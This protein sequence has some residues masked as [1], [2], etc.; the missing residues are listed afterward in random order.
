MLH[1]QMLAVSNK[2]RLYKKRQI[3]RFVRNEQELEVL[4]KKTEQEFIA[5]HYPNG[6]GKH[7]HLNSNSEFITV[8]SNYTHVPDVEFTH[9]ITHILGY[10]RI[11]GRLLEL[12]KKPTQ[13]EK[14]YSN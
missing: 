1:V 12:L 9:Y 11:P 8:F 5:D 7:A 4:H 3:G 6:I 14:Y 13:N 10:K 2:G